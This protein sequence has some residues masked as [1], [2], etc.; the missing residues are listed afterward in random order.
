[1]EHRLIDL[2]VQPSHGDDGSINGIIS[3]AVDVTDVV[4]GRQVEAVS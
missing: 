3:F 2:V 4:S 1:L